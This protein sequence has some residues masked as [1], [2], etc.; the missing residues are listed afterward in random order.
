MEI[1]SKRHAE[2]RDTGRTVESQNQL[3]LSV[4][5]IMIIE[6]VVVVV[7]MMMIIKTPGDV[8]PFPFPHKS[9]MQPSKN[10]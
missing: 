3:V 1:G 2:R 7:M 10:P 8:S 6:V 5:H 9:P 4:C